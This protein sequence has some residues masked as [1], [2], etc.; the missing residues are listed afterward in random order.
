MER[1]QVIILMKK[2]ETNNMQVKSS[3]H[4]KSVTCTQMYTEHWVQQC[5]STDPEGSNESCGSWVLESVDYYTVCQDDGSGSGSS[6]TGDPCVDYG[7][8]NIPTPQPA[9]LTTSTADH[10]LPHTNTLPPNHTSDTQVGQN[11]FF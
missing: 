3:V 1:L 2:K 5:W 4:L 10:K 11:M 9:P 8:C 7:Y 6:L